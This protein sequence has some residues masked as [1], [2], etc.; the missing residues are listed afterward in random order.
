MSCKKRKEFK[1]NLKTGVQNIGTEQDA[2]KTEA[3]IK[4]FGEDYSEFKNKPNEAIEHLLKVKQGQVV[5]AMNRADVGDIDFIWGNAY[6]TEKGEVKGKGLA[7][8]FLKHG[9]DA[10]KSI[11]Q[12]IRD[13][14]IVVRSDTHVQINNKDHAAVIYFE[15]F[16][17]EKVWLMTHYELSKPNSQ[18]LPDASFKAEESD[19]LSSKAYNESII[20]QAKE[21]YKQDSKLNDYANSTIDMLFDG[22]FGVLEGGVD[23]IKWG[24]EKMG[25]DIKDTV[26]DR[27]FF[28]ITKTHK[29]V[30]EVINSY[31]NL[32]T[33]IYKEAAA[34]K[35]GL[36]TL[37]K[38]DN[39]AL[40][41]VLNG[42]L[43]PQDLSPTLLPFYEKFRRVIDK[44]ADMLVEAGVLN[45]KDKIQH[46]LKRYYEDFV[47]SGTT[48]GGS[49]AYSKL[50]KR[51]NL[52][53]AERLAKGMLED[54]TFVIPNT[55]AEQNILLQKARVLKELAEKFASDEPKDGYV[56]MSNENALDKNKS[57]T[58][59]KKYGALGGKWVPL[60]LKDEISYSNMFGNEMNG[61]QKV[62]YPLIDHLK[63]NLTVKNPVT[64]AY[65]IASNLLLSG[66]NGDLLAVG[67]MLLMRT[68]EPDK[69]K[70][71]LDKA[72]KRG[73]NSYLDDFEKSELVLN[74]DQS[75]NVVSSIW[76]NIYMAKG[77]KVGDA[78]RFLYDWE[79]KIFKLSAFNKL[80]EEGM[81]EATAYKKAVEVYVDYSTPLPAGV[82][83]LDKSGLMPFIH[84]QYKATPATAK[85]M[86]KHPIRTLL[87]STGALML[88]TSAFT[89]DENELL[90][91]DWAEDKLNLFGIAEW[92]DLGNG[93]Y[94]NAGRMIPG[95]K[96]EFEFGGITKS[97]VDIAKGK[98]PLGYDIKDY[99]DGEAFGSSIAPRT[100]ALMENYMPSVTLG[101]YA[102]RAT[103]IALGEVGVIEPKKN[104]YDEDM[105]YKELMLRASGIR[106]FNEEK[107]LQKRASKANTKRKKDNK[108]NTKEKRIN[109]KVYRERVSKLKK[110]GR[111]KRIKVV[112]KSKK[113]G[114][115]R[116]KK[117]PKFFTI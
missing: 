27:K 110:A 81:D 75:V 3:D 26:L 16:G 17:K 30:S 10:V 43:K 48:K 34:L 37:D 18:I 84:Y 35:T 23:V 4:N 36:E 105:S 31:N 2:I 113:K 54:A 77:S 95:T 107:E 11:P 8:I 74:T 45:E 33:N 116:V 55:I 111:K 42:D 85:V 90:L 41:R 96:F 106:L 14:K 102:Q 40:V 69:F 66:I 82:K 49:V 97:V 88:G 5:G 92:V 115:S 46:Y 70:V 15:Y 62:L 24:V 58:G 9:E 7:K 20:S 12:T 59:L 6:T 60:E 72:N 57:D 89:N 112:D 63:V 99:G 21:Y 87:F 73:L 22:Y 114:F 100:L 103:Q 65:N 53:H 94:L 52:S 67:K 109:E 29:Q 51:K 38:E 98:S 83:M 28:T 39:I 19:N 91:P 47:E 86:A 108:D 32:K 50:K 44:N 117:I 13:G 68:T 76:K 1:E 78:V 101:R 93:W 80:L 79:D 71:I 64:H 56:L 25:V 104:Y 61:V